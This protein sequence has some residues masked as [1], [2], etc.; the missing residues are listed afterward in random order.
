MCVRKFN[1]V[2]NFQQ[3][4]KML[5]RRT[6]SRFLQ[7]VPVDHS[8]YHMF[9]ATLESCYWIFVLLNTI[10]MEIFPNFGSHFNFLYF[11]IFSSKVFFSLNLIPIFLYINSNSYYCLITVPIHIL[12]PFIF[13]LKKLFSTYFLLFFISII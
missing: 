4:T 11:L 6:I 2:S 12:I 9:P 13:Y 7:F 5:N 3:L 8:T 1:F 10:W